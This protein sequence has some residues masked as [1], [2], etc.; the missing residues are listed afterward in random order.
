ME[1]T[2]GMVVKSMYGHDAGSFYVVL[3][4]DGQFAYIADGKLRA[5]GKPKKKNKKHLAIT[6]TLASETDMSTDKKIRQFLWSF[7]HGDE[8]P[9]TD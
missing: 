7:N 2:K 9:E 3:S 5:R 6:R 8:L 1:I 4:E